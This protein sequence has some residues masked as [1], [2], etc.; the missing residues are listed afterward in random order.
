MPKPLNYTPAAAQ[1]RLTPDQEV[2][3][4]LLTLH[5]KGVLDLANTVAEG[6]TEGLD[7]I[8]E[9]LDHS[10]TKN[11][12]ANAARLIML[13]GEL[14]PDVLLGLESGANELNSRVR[15]SPPPSLFGL[16]RKIRDPDVRRGLDMVLGLLKGVGMPPPEG[17]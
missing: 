13:L 2:Q 14:N 10:G 11:A 5:N 12:L 7:L 16:V 15:K 3:R 17:V 1:I 6:A 4:L 9:R 8:L